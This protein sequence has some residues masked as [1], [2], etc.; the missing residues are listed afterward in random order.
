M[1]YLKDGIVEIQDL[2]LPSEERFEKGPVVIIECVQEIPCNP[3]VEAC[4][5]SAI[6]M[7]ESINHV[8]V[9][10]FE[11]C[12]GCG[13]CIAQCPGLA[14]F[15]VDRTFEEKRALVSLP[16]EFLPL[17][18]KGE[19]ITL[20]DRAGQ[21]CGEGEVIRIRNA[22]NQD[23]TP[24]ITL[25]VEKSLEMRVRFFRRKKNEAKK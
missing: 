4:P 20:I 19:R 14:I 24:V 13:V 2:Q 7:P 17:P 16:Y 1:N 22:K 10:D 15:V 6:T 9:V 21:P 5:F 3:C 12:T 18:E 23:R 25:A 11:K 8:P